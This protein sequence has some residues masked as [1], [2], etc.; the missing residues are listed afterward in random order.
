MAFGRALEE[1]FEERG[2][3]FHGWSIL[4]DLSLHIPL[5]DS[6]TR[7]SAL[8]SRPLT[9]GML[10]VFEPHQILARIRHPVGDRLA[11]EGFVRPQMEMLLDTKFSGQFGNRVQPQ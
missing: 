10:P 3:D 7:L 2:R 9:D 8:L 11:A 6:R 4:P 5:P 1:G